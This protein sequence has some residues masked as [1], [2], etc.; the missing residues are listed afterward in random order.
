M[1]E[2]KWTDRRKAKNINGDINSEFSYFPF[3]YVL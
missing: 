1:H 3:I 2:Q